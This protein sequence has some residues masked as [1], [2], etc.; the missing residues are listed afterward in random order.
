MAIKFRI[1]KLEVM[2]EPLSAWLDKHLACN[3]FRLLEIKVS[4]LVRYADLPLR[5]RDPFD[6]LLIA[7]SLAENLSIISNDRAF[8]AYQV[9]R[10]W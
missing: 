9:Q 3:S 10:V 8:D 6:G 5:H 2:P 4:H 1:G 7:R